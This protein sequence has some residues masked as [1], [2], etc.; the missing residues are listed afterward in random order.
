[1]SAVI[2][3]V[4]VVVKVQSI[5]AAVATQANP[6]RLYF[7]VFFVSVITHHLVSSDPVPPVV[8]IKMTG[9]PHKSI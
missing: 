2:R 6:D 9:G 3:Q 1:M 7:S 4:F 8:G 5:R